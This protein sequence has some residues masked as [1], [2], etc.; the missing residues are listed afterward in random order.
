M[1]EKPKLTAEDKTRLKNEILSAIDG[2]K[3]LPPSS[4][5]SVPADSD[6][7]TAPNIKIGKEPAIA[8]TEAAAMKS[9]PKKTIY[10]S[11]SAET[12]KP[13]T[14]KIDKINIE[15]KS[16]LQVEK[17]VPMKYQRQR[18][19]S[20]IVIPENKVKITDRQQQRRHNQ[21][22]SMLRFIILLLIIIIVLLTANLF[23]LAK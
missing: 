16:N 8:I 23:M 13:E 22:L 4:G 12:P 6:A 7:K 19:K 2:D 9:V 5:F 11:D 20:V 18:Q 14:P 3:K 21:G 17:N 1:L 10:T 15:N